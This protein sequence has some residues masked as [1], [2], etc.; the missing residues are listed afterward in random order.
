MTVTSISHA[1]DLN[2]P[3][4]E[5]SAD[6][7]TCGWVDILARAAAQTSAIAISGIM[8]SQAIFSSS[9]FR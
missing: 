6:E 2:A 7:A 4:F 5:V 8:M 1:L 9:S 3:R